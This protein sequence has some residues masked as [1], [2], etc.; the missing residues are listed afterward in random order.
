MPNDIA[1]FIPNAFL[2]TGEPLQ[3]TFRDAALRIVV[4]A[5]MQTDLPDMVKIVF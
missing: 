2:R 3:F 1:E 4:P 5:S